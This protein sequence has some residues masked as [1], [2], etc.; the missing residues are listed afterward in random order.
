MSAWCQVS[1]IVRVDGF[2]DKDFSEVFG[3]QL[4][5]DSPDELWQEADEHPERFLPM[6]SEGSI[7]MTVWKNPHGNHADKYTI[8]LFGSLRDVWSPH[9]IIEWFKE[10]VESLS[11]VR[12]AVIT[13]DCG[14]GL[15]ME[16][17][18]Y[19]EDEE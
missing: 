1:G 14:V 10:K 8:S 17:W 4:E 18:T 5:W 7:K 19:G 15:G 3:K 6:G 11:L 13:A 12:Q 2:A 16:T 9:P